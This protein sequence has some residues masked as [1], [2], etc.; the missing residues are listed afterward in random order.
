[1]PTPTPSTKSANGSIPQA[2]ANTDGEWPSR[3]QAVEGLP[4]AEASAAD[5]MAAPIE[6]LPEQPFSLKAQVRKHPVLYIGLGALA[7]AGL[8]AILG[9]GAIVR[10]ARPIVVRAVRPIL[11]RAAARRPLE[12]ARMAARN[13]KAAARFV[14][15]LR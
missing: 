7:V 6:K 9:R 4:D 8:A 12:V 2:A 5:P 1:M 13:P 14:A 10:T 11:L 15:G 3:I